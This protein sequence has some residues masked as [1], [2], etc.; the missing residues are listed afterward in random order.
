MFCL[1][2]WKQELTWSL[3][4]ENDF[5]FSFL[6]EDSYSLDDNNTIVVVDGGNNYS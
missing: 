3:E 4:N 1:R 6:P 2:C 5:S